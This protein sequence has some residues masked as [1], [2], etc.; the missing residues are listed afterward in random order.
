MTVEQNIG[1]VPRLLG[2]DRCAKRANARRGAARDARRW[3]RPT[4]IG[5]YPRELSGG[6]AQR[7]GVARA[8]AADPP[9]LLMDEPFGARRSGQSR[10]DPGR[11]PAMQSSLAQD[12]HVREPRH[13]R[14]GED[15]RP[16][17]DLSGTVASPGRERP[18]HCSP[19][20]TTRSSKASSVATGHSS[21]C[22]AAL[23]G[24][25]GAVQ[26]R[27][28]ATACRASLRSMTCAPR[29]RSWWK[30][31]TTHAL[32]QRGRKRQP[33]M[34]RLAEIGICS[35]GAL[36]ARCHHDRPADAPL[37]RRRRDSSRR[38]GRGGSGGVDAILKYRVEIVHLTQPAH[39]AGA[40]FGRTRDRRG[41]APGIALSRR[42]MR[43]VLRP[44]A[45]RC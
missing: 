39:P 1:V 41:R 12:R 37:P 13:R 15:G 42:S 29:C 25:A 17:R 5:R 2:W 45:A 34:V 16:H 14:S 7:V 32:L 11:I 3:I 38:R 43:R 27:I 35:T 28:S 10:S 30:A 6:Q 22:A 24:S 4:F 26:P 23:R 9:V 19:P 44:G 33:A 21:D 8:L 31:I 36:G 18:M 40:L 20:P